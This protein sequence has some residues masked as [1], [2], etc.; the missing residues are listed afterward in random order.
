MKFQDIVTIDRRLCEMVKFRSNGWRNVNFWGF[1]GLVGLICGI[2]LGSV[3]D[4]ELGDL[5]LTV[6]VTGMF[7]GLERA[8]HPVVHFVRTFRIPLSLRN[9]GT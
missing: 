8:S 6:G 2:F 9:G 1:M 7:V 5:W 4:E 3:T